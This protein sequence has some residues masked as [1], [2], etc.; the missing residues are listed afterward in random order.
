MHRSPA[1]RA[2]EYSVQG[3]ASQE[4]ED[5]CTPWATAGHCQLQPRPCSTCAAAEAPRA[6][7]PP[8]LSSVATRTGLPCL[9]PHHTS[10]QTPCAPSSSAALVPPPLHLVTHVLVA[11]GPATHACASL[12]AGLQS[13]LSRNSGVKCEMCL[14]ELPEVVCVAH[15][16]VMYT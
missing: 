16:R 1:C 14:P 15:S 5:R 7:S 4:N 3:E 12:S 9:T 6:V 13:P 11:R 10:N 2:H 8:V